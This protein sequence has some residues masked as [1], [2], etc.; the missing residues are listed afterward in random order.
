[1]TVPGPKDDELHGVR[2]F[3]RSVRRTIRWRYRRATSGL[4][5]LPDFVVIGA[6][7]SGTTSLFDYFRDH[8]Q[9]RPAL[10]KELHFYDLHYERGVAWYRA[11][12]PRMRQLGGGRITGEATPNYL[13]YPSTPERLHGVTPNAKLIVLLRNPADRAHS[14]WRLRTM[15]GAETL[16]FAEA[17]EREL[18]QEH[19]D[20][21]EIA[22]PKKVGQHLR[23]LYLSKSRYAEQLERWLKLFPR[24][25]LLV[26]KSED[27]FENP[28]GALGEMAEFL[29]ID[30]W[31][32]G[33]FRAVNKAEPAP[34]DPELRM[35][36]VEYFAPHNEKLEA[37][38]GR[39]FDWK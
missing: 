26:I 38:I 5:A 37:L 10:K 8:P 25:Q 13:V 9:V 1:M 34:I 24:E 31:Q 6:Q 22:D 14:A 2:L 39:T 3:A 32:P 35:R 20:V 29:G 17:L 7:R 28:D 11:N 33:A 15:E 19:I 23:F 21:A 36:L 12:F 4:R 27:L 30:P 18:A 16:S